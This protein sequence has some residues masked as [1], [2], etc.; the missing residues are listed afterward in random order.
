M[1]ERPLVIAFD[2][3]GR[4]HSESGPAIAYGDGVAVHAWH[5][6]RVEGWIVDQPEGITVATIDA[7]RNAEIRRVLVERFGAE[8]LVREGGAEL[9]DEDETGRLWRRPLTSNRWS[10]EEPIVMVEVLNSTPEPDG[11]RKTY[12]LRVPPSTKTAREVVAWT[13]GLGAVRYQPSIES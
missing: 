8:R 7:A 12:F 9:L 10:G 11:S 2:D 3:A 6:T 5:G 4:L 13:F 1:S